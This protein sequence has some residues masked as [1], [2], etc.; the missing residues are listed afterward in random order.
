MAEAVVDLLEVVHVDEEEDEFAMP[1]AGLLELLLGEGE[2]ATAVVQPRELVNEGERTQRVF[3]PLAVRDVARGDRDAV[4]EWDDL[5]MD[6]RRHIVARR[7]LELFLEHVRGLQHA[8]V[9]LEVAVGAIGGDQ[10]AEALPDH[11]VPRP[12]QER[13][14]A[15]V[16]VDELEV[17]HVAR[18]VTH[19]AQHVERVEASVSC[20]AKARLAF[21][22]RAFR[23]LPQAKVVADHQEGERCKDQDEN[24]P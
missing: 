23:L 2:K 15:R 24:E 4:I 3:L 16:E 19:R 7:H 13:F 6:P 22:E 11:Q 10:L 18:A 17:Q 9:L 5:M 8:T 14:G 21:L 20:R 1:A 12:A